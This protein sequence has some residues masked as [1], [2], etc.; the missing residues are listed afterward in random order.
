[1]N[2]FILMIKNEVL[3]QVATDK[4]S[5]IALTFCKVL[6]NPLTCSSNYCLIVIDVYIG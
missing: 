6:F 5:D 2:K 4:L 3:Q 1:M